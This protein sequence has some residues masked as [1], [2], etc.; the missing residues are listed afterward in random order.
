[1]KMNAMTLKDFEIFRKKSTERRS[2]FHATEAKLNPE[3]ALAKAQDEFSRHCSEGIKTPNQFFYNLILDDGTCAGYLWFAI[4][5]RNNS[6]KTFINDIL[7]DEA[8]RGR[9]L[10]KFMLTW[11]E[12]KTAE[13]VCNEIGL[14]VLGG[15]SVARSLYEK[16]GY[17][18]TNLD[19][20]KKI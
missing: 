17:S 3:E 13:L 19:M 6:R 14:H 8:F 4:K 20:A 15:N 1:M 18:V 7:V 2:Q 16:M 9:G 10:S 11:L 12:R 5:E